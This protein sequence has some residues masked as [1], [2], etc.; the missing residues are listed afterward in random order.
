VRS[1]EVG[2]AYGRIAGENRKILC[3]EG[4]GSTS[5]IVNRI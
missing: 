5:G 3:L 4:L 2:E 1:I